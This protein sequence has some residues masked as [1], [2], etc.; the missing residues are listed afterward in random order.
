MFTMQHLWA[1]L[2]AVVRGFLLILNTCAAQ[3]LVGA[4]VGPEHTGWCSSTFAEAHQ[5]LCVP[6]RIG[7]RPPP[8]QGFEHASSG[9][10][11]QNAIAIEEALQCI[12]RAKVS[13]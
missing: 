6:P 3:V 8:R 5:C 13:I 12:E 9:A 1:P 2:G 11:Q 10:R 7:L 4:Q